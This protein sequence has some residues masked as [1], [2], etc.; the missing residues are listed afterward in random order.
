M[1][2]SSIVAGAIFPSPWLINYY[3]ASPCSTIWCERW[4]WSR[5]ARRTHK[6]FPIA[7]ALPTGLII[8]PIAVHIPLPGTI[9]IEVLDPIEVDGDPDDDQRVERYYDEILTTMQSHL[10][11]LVS[12]LPRRGLLRRFGQLINRARRITK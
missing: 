8:G 1:N 2:S 11:E 5:P 7:L 3:F 10:D 12:E 9:I 6:V 4:G